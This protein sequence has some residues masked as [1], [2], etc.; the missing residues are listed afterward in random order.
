[1]LKRVLLIGVLVVLA[2]AS[3]SCIF[4]PPKTDKGGPPPTTYTFYDLSKEWHV[5]ANIESAYNARK[6]E[7]YDQLL[8]D[9]FTFFLYHGDVGGEIPASWDRATEVLYNTRL[10]DKS[11]PTNTCKSISMDLQ[12][13]PNNISW[14]D[15]VPDQSKYPGETWKTAVIYYAFRF[16]VLPDTQYESVA[17]A[18]GQFTIRNIGTAEKPQWRLVE[19]SD[20]GDGL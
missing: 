2:G 15:V 1:M 11:Y 13:D 8:D 3:A 14:V 12:F 7:K 20:L 5:L 10:F 19:F 17:G 9:N 4:D 6:I 18:R 16:D